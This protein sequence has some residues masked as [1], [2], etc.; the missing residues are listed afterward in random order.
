MKMATRTDPEI[1]LLL[2][3]I[4]QAYDHHAWHG[5]N[6]KSSLRRLTPAEAAWRPGGKRHNIWELVVHAAYWKYTVR[7][8]LLGE[9]RG[10]PSRSRE[11][12]GLN[13]RPVER[14]HNGRQT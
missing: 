9:K 4:D 1:Q 2:D 8:R 6:L 14:K 7:R 3:V 11:A 10:V 13:D 12:I 5:T